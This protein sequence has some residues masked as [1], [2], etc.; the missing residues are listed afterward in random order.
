MKL[1]PGIR[2]KSAVCSFGGVLVKAPTVGEKILCGSQSVLGL[3]EPVPDIAKL[4]SAEEGSPSIGK[5]YV[6]EVSGLEVLC[7]KPGFGQLSFE[8]RV[9]LLKQPKPLPSSD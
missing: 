8:G 7:T 2:F 1:S 5:R 6:D 3:D 4:T 9:L